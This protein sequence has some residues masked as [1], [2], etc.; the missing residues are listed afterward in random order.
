MSG[1][2]T[3]PEHCTSKLSHHFNEN[4]VVINQETGEFSLKNPTDAL[5]VWV[6]LSDCILRAV[7]LKKNHLPFFLRESLL[8]CLHSALR[9]DFVGDCVRKNEDCF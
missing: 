9:Q 5:K 3:C 1:N 2:N 8:F 7:H 6:F 4:N